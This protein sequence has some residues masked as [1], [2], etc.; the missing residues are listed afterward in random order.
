M[1]YINSASIQ[2]GQVIQAN[3]VLNIINAFND[4]DF[5]D[6]KVKGTASF[7]EVNIK[8][9][10]VTGTASIETFI[11][12]YYSSSV[13]YAS[14]STKFG[15]STDDTHTFTG[16]LGITGSLR[17][18]GPT[19][20]GVLGKNTQ[21]PLIF[22]PDTAAAAVFYVKNSGS[23]VLGTGGDPYSGGVDFL[24]FDGSGNTT[25]IGNQTVTGSVNI[26]GRILAL[27]LTGSLLGTAS[28]ASTASF[29][30]SA[31]S[32]SFATTASFALNA[33]VTIFTGSFA[34]TGSNTFR[35]SQTI[36][37]SVNITGSLT[38]SGSSTFTNIGPTILRGTFAVVGEDGSAFISASRTVSSS[39]SSSI[40]TTT[41][42]FSGSAFV[43]TDGGSLTWNSNFRVYYTGVSGSGETELSTLYDAV[44]DSNKYSRFKIGINNRPQITLSPSGS[45]QSYKLYVYNEA[46]STWYAKS[47]I[48]STDLQT[49]VTVNL[50]ADTT[51]AF[52]NDLLA[53]GFDATSDPT[54]NTNTITYNQQFTFT[55]TQ[56]AIILDS[57]RI[58]P[59]SS[60]TP[61]FTGSDGQFIFGST[62]G[63]H[64]IYV[65][66]NNAWRS[67]SLV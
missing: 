46:D 62:G 8:N 51:K 23:L 39:V 3:H 58:H 20:L 55:T 19:Q 4:T 33:G 29:V 5:T 61:T 40:N 11:T 7:S 54:S 26:T 1:A 41:T 17:V 14:G 36:S 49:G 60:G 15:D 10:K 47:D 50:S 22:N 30:R 63:S 32:S 27:S 12:T 13:I 24:R 31:I 59:T 66:M 6:V 34:T 53:A 38:I 45:I 2:N 21:S 28:L 65:W 16:S 25:F 57:P 48:T 64:Y 67:S 43:S 44:G 56:S 52:G 37:G 35:G 9:L 18:E 42:S